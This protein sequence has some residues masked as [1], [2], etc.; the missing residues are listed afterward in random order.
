MRKEEELKNGLDGSPSMYVRCSK[1]R[2]GF[3]ISGAM[4]IQVEG[5]CLI[6]C[7]KHNPELKI[8]AD[9]I[10]NRNPKKGRSRSKEILK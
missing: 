6:F 9:K 2:S 8:E 5:K 1:C 4:R 10:L 3:F 7:E